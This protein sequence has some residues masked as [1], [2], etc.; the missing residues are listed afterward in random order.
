MRSFARMPRRDTAEKDEGARSAA[1]KVLRRPSGSG[2]TARR[3]VPS[4]D[5]FRSIAGELRKVTWPTREEIRRLTVLVVAVS[6]ATGM[7]LGAIDII[8]T[9]MVNTVVEF[10][11]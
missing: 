2:A 6:V 1:P 8:F 10:G 4:L 5:F 9:Q 7:A 3:V 11:L